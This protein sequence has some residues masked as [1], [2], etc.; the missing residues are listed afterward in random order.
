MAEPTKL[1]LTVVTPQGHL[2]YT[3]AEARARKPGVL[4]DEVTAPG[5]LGEFG[6]LPG[7]LPFLTYLKAGPIEFRVGPEH[8][9]LAVKGGL[10]EVGPDKVSILADDAELA[11]EIGSAHVK[12]PVNL[13]SRLPS[14]A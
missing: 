6:V 8:R 14:S 12:T 10:A 13:D 3:G 2:L 7:H 11:E 4:V 9:Y 1:N 5:I